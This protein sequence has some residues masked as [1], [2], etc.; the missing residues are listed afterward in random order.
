[1][2]HFFRILWPIVYLDIIYRNLQSTEKPRSMADSK[3]L[4]HLEVVRL[5]EQ[6]SWKSTE[7]SK[8]QNHDI[9][10]EFMKKV[11]ISKTLVFTDLSLID[12]IHCN[13][14]ITEVW[15]VHP[16]VDLRNESPKLEEDVPAF[17]HKQK[18]KKK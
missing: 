15:T 18:S 13:T 1:M 3:A 11:A 6:N 14:E 16:G 8:E 12:L 4:A 17:K 5:L 7:L 10:F 2:S 9:Q